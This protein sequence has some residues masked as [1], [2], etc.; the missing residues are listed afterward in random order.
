MDLR[1]LAFKVEF[2]GSTAVIKEM[3]GATNKLKDTAMNAAKKLE[4]MEK[5]FTKVGKGLMM[6]VTAPVVGLGT[7]A[8]KTVADFDDAMSKVQAMSGATGEE[9][10]QLRELAKEYGATTRFSASEAAE[11]MTF[12]AMAGL[13]VNEIIDTMP[14]LLS[15]AAA[16][17]MD[18]GRAADI[19]TNI[20][21]GFGM[22]AHEAGRV[23]DVLAKGASSA[24]TSVEQLGDAMAVVAP[25]ASTLGLEVEGLTAA[26]GF[27]SD[28]GIQGQQ[29]GRMLRQGMLRLASPTGEAEKLIKELGINVFDA[30]GNMKTLDKVVGELAKGLKGMSS[31][32]QTAALATIFGAESVAGWTALLDR[33]AEELARYTS[34]LQASQGAATAM[35]ATMEDNIGGAFRTMKS[36]IEGLLFEIGDVL[37]DDVRRRAVGIANL[38]SKFNNL[39]GETKRGIVALL[40][41]AA[42]AGPVIWAVGKVAGITSSVIGVFNTVSG[43]IAVVKTGAVAATPAIAALAKVFALVT[44]PVAIA[45]AKIVAVAAVVKFAVGAF[46]RGYEETGSIMGGIVNIFKEGAEKIRSLWQGLKDFLKNPIKGTVQLAGKLW[47]RITGRN[48]PDGS[49]RTGLSRVPYDGYIAEL[50]K[51]EEVLAAD[52]PRN[53]NN[54]RNVARTKQTTSQTAGQTT[55]QIAGKL[56]DKIT[57][58]NKQ[59]ER[60]R[61]RLSR[62]P[63]DGHIVELHKGE[64]FPIADDPKNI[65]NYKNITRTSNIQTTTSS[66]KIYYNPTFNI[67][68]NGNAT[69]QEITDLENRMRKVARESFQDFFY[70]LSLKMA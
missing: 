23:A 46:K 38:A 7:A 47:D 57:G 34:E 8:I 67:E 54:Y 63:Y 13:E 69:E 35:A 53:I 25:V 11:G 12:L 68:V 16:S 2:D 50:H 42:A 55:T 22:A 58:R 17:G 44:S 70:E 21:S 10:E 49:H 36:A 56:W 6:K 1:N 32:A 20:L 45:A 19:T 40:G 26:V 43:A 15:L 51:G 9:F 28:A 30:E 29:A 59:D 14:G 65:N 41:F 61:T 64:D 62:V 27:M 33:G 60:H 39:D 3:D 4:G 52:D 66:P 18:L 37:K 31:Q 5:S 48:K 24:N